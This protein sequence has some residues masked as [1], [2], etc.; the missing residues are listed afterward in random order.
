MKNV[1]F[2]HTLFHNDDCKIIV[3][4]PEDIKRYS[5]K[6]EEQIKKDILVWSKC[7]FS[8]ILSKDQRDFE[9]FRREDNNELDIFFPIG[10]SK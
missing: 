9:I 5:G 6:E 2:K 7:L 8:V 1:E 3:E 4:L 10:E